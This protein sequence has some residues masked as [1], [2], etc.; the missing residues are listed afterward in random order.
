MGFRPRCQHCQ[1]NGGVCVQRD[2]MAE[3]IEKMI[4]A[5]VIVMAS[6]A[7]C[8]NLCTKECICME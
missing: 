8:D 7:Y 2:D 3:I 4:Q 1:Q 5:D 6:P